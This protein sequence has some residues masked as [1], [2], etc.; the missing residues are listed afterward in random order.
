MKNAVIA[1]EAIA[2]VLLALYAYKVTVDAE[3]DNRLSAIKDALERLTVIECRLDI[4][5][6]C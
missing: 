4:R 6:N 5:P 2:L 3:S 1:A